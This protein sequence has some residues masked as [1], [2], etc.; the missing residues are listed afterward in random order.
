LII[1][2]DFGIST[3]TSKYVAEFNATDK[4]KLKLVLFNSLVIILALGSIVTILTLVFGERFLGDKFYYIVYTLPLLFLAPITSLYDG[5][6]RGLKRFKELAVIS[7]SVGGFSLVFVYLLITNY[8]LI[9]ALIAQVLFYL[10]LTFALSLRYGNLYFKIDK[11]LIK[12]V[13]NYSLIIGVSSIAYFL[14][15]RVD[16]L[17]LEHFGYIKEIGYYELINQGFGLM[18]LPFALLAQ[19]IAPNI[20]RHFSRKNYSTVKTKLL[21]YMK[22]IIPIAV[23]IS[24]LFYFIF[25]E[26]IRLFLPE[27]YLKEM[28]ISISILSFLIPA[29]IW[30]VFQ[31]QSFVVATGF[32]KIIAISTLIGGVLNVIFD[33]IFINWLGFVGVFFVTLFIHFLNISFQTLYYFNK[34]KRLK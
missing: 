9:G 32:A 26:I 27:Y 13:F 18:F 1:F 33:I 8:G 20:T 15:S 10:L 2:G 4:S 3:A 12:K 17:V 16:I 28:I 24:I 19:V 5:I 30:G 29:K 7:L 11:D 31:T 21:F 23:L 6:F 25:P 14:Y 34:I 22:L